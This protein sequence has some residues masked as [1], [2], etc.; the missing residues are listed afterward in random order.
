MKW[1]CCVNVTLSSKPGDRSDTNLN[2]YATNGISGHTNMLKIVSNA[3]IYLS[4]TFNKTG[5]FFMER[6]TTLDIYESQD[7]IIRDHVVSLAMVSFLFV[8]HPS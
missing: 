1:R 3:H 8:A 6:N 7:D 5:F 4:P 2:N